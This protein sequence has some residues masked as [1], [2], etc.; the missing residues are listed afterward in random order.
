V[1]RA[2][3]QGNLAMT[4]TLVSAAM[5]FITLF[6]GYAVFRS[7]APFWPPLNI[8]KVPT[9]WPWVSTLIIA[10]SSISCAKCRSFSEQ[11]KWKMARWYS[12][13]TLSLALSF[14]LSQWLLWRSLNHSGILV[15]SGV[16]ASILYG[17]T[18]IHAAHVVLGVA[19]LA[20]M[21]WLLKAERQENVF[22]IINVE[23]FWHFLGIVWFFM[24]LGLF[25][26]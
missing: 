7:N 16:F 22:K 1:R 25:I 10:L 2:E 6:M 12:L 9:T 8:D 21:S 4:V 19:G 15:S 23:K 3:L 17:F 24:F 20:Y 5:L 26:F 13:I 11:G 18:W 14:M